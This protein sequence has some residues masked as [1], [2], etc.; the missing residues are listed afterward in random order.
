MK[1][2]YWIGVLL[3]A[4]LACSSGLF[5][6]VQDVTWSRILA[7]LAAYVPYTGSSAD[8]DLGTHALKAGSAT[9]G[10]TSLRD[11]AGVLERQNAGG[12]WSPVAGRTMVIDDNFVTPLATGFVNGSAAE[13]GSLSLKRV[14]ADTAGK[15]SITA[16]QGL[17]FSGGK[18]TP[19]WNDP[20][21]SLSPAFTRYPGR[22]LVCR[23]TFP[24]SSQWFVG[25]MDSTTVYPGYGFQI[26]AANAIRSWGENVLIAT[27]TPG[28]EH[29]FWVVFLAAGHDMYIKGGIYP[30]PTL[31]WSSPINSTAT[32]YPQAASFDGSFSLR[33]FRVPAAVYLMPSLAYD[34]FTR[35]DGA[36]G[37]TE[38]VGMSGQAITARIW[39]S[40]VGTVAVATN[41]AAASAL[42]G[43]IAIATAPCVSDDV[44]ADLAYTRSD[45]T[46]GLIVRYTDADNYVRAV[47]D[48]TNAK[49]IKR[50]AGTE[51]TLID[52][53][54]TYS[55]GALLRVIANG[56]S[57]SLFYNQLA[58]G[59]VQTVTGLTGTAC[60]IYASSVSDTFDN[61]N[62]NP[63]G[64]A[65]EHAALD[66]LIGD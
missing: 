47:H 26:L 15:V 2:R 13:P 54:A 41:K 37:S 4:I 22:I 5:A 34:T 49:L 16:A 65:G 63:I 20:L 59:T 50:V 33:S 6:G 3:I 42:T 18:P 28:V 24:G 38:V 55:A 57:I 8:L 27:L 39:T 61:F 12:S 48:G 23:G 64:T 21:V 9:I 43:G 51:T 36:L 17:T 31:V 14:V 45:G 29:T 52:T 44:M 40:N 35:A 32:L 7:H 1:R 56:T 62:V 25:F 46:S 60:G 53:A 19:G 66:S 10:T 58:V 30:Y 11:N